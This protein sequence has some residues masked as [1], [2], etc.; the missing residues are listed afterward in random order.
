MDNK[1]LIYKL[2]S[3]IPQGKV[4]TYG[5]IAKFF[6]IKSARSI[7]QF[8]HQNLDPKNIP[9]HRVV[10]SNGT[11][12]K[13]YAFGGEETQ[14][15][16][17]EMEGVKFYLLNNHLQDKRV[18]LKRSQWRPTAV[19]R[20]YFFLLKK[21]GHPGPW[22]WFNQGKKATKEEIVIGAILTQNTNWSNAEKALNNL[23]VNRLNSLKSIYKLGKKNLNKLKNLIYPSGFYNQKGERLFNL[24]KFIIENYKSLDNFFKLPIKKARNV[25]L[26]LKGIGEETADT[27][28]L[29]AGDKS[30]FVIDAYTRKFAIH[31][32]KNELSL[33]DRTK[34][35]PYKI[36]Q[37]FFMDNL[38][39][40][41]K[42]YQ[43]YHALIVRW[44]KEKK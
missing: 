5:Q 37:K 9:C 29:Y 27:I 32:L 7:G 4:L 19:L 43:N 34:M 36:L 16:K 20:E 26:S 24:T 1:K 15:R 13:N 21:F 23:R 40:D 10:F 30:I 38:P 39:T 12:S 11:L 14:E 22:P 33:L 17:L 6:K 2:V 41:T 18:D 8:L 25:L 28:L 3:L 35:P 44:G 42:L 31:Y